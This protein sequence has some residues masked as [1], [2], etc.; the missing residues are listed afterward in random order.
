MI[1][2]VQ[3]EMNVSLDVSLPKLGILWKL[4]RK[5]RIPEKKLRF[6]IQ[7]IMAN[8]LRHARGPILPSDHYINCPVF[9]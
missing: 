9:R 1:Q 7:K 2:P 3:L 6:L 5:S 4:T 8:E